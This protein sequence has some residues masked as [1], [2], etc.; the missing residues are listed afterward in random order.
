MKIDH[1]HLVFLLL[2]TLITTGCE[3]EKIEKFD[4]GNLPENISFNNDIKPIFEN[5]CKSC[6]F[7]GT[8]P[9]L[10]PSEAYLNLTSGGYLN[11]E[12]PEESEFYVIITTGNMAQYA[13]DSDRAYILKWIKQG[14][15]D[16]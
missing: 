16:N 11:V 7:G 1:V 14:A 5:Q 12:K 9:N 3:S 4:T 13:T 10:S 6:H 15:S 2:L 8:S